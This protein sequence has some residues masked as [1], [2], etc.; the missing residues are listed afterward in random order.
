MF[1]LYSNFLV[2]SPFSL[3]ELIELAGKYMSK[4]TLTAVGYLLCTVDPLTCED[5]FH[6]LS[7]V[8]FTQELAT[9]FFAYCSVR[10]GQM[11]AWTSPS[12]VR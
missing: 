4:D 5:F 8:P 12:I 9:Y 2:Q 3:A 1:N 11:N 6:N 7:Q 10:G